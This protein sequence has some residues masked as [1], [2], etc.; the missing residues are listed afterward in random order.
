MAIVQNYDEIYQSP[1]LR[2]LML[3]ISDVSVTLV[4]DL[5][6]EPDCSYLKI[7]WDDD[8][9]RQYDV[10]RLADFLDQPYDIENKL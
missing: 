3:H 4:W 1:N 10:E 9:D 6:L 5:S 2:D 8:L 7:A